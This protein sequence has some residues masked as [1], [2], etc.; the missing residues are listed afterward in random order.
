[1]IPSVPVSGLPWEH[2]SLDAVASALAGSS[3]RWWLSG[4]V[5]LDHWLG[6]V[7]RDRRN[8]DI[9]TIPGDVAELVGDLRAPLSAWVHVEGAWVPFAEVGPD[10]DLQP[11]LVRDDE[12]NAWVLQINVEDGT[13]DAWLY[14]RDPR[15][16]LPWD[17]AVID[18]GGIP[19]GAP[20][21]QLVWKA[22]RPRPED[23]ADKD[24]VLPS[25]S[26]EAR[27]WYEQAILRLHPHSSWS[28]H[29]R[30]PTFPGRASW[31]HKRD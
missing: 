2:V 4:G 13:D 9:S 22:L 24:A 19:T 25:L 27:A 8:T 1:M 5:A 10:V 23:D 3:A 12:R 18:V 7:T 20:Q 6:R 15:L 31:N 17:T 14:R 21:V 11:I 16:Q 28:I 30:T 29:V 26:S